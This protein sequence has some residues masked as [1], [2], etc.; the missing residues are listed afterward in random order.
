MLTVEYSKSDSSDV[1]KDVVEVYFD[2]DGLDLLLRKLNQLRVN[3]GHEH[4]MTPSWAG[5]ELT[6][7][8]QGSGNTL[9]NHLCVIL[10]N[11]NE[12]I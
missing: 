7:D 5:A 10:T 8:I 9:I 12:E 6:E 4:F 11:D 1:N 2:N 3:G